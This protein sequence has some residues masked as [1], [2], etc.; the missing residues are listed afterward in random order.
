[1]GTLSPQKYI[2]HTYEFS[3]PQIITHAYEDV[4]PQNINYV[5]NM[6]IHEIYTLKTQL[7]HIW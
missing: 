2:T 6:C 7:L 1:M 3:L 4:L 5:G